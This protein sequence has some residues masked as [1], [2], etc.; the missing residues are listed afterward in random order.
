MSLKGQKE[1]FKEAQ[2]GINV[3]QESEKEELATSQ[4]PRGLAVFAV[5][6]F[7][8][9]A[10]ILLRTPPTFEQVILATPSCASMCL[11]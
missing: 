10:C 8:K 5:P 7:L 3:T 2:A 11:L 6:A 9:V 4:F 1:R